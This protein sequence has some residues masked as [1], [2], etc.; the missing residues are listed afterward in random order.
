MAAS[1]AAISGN[2]CEDRNP[3]TPQAS[4]IPEPRQRLS[5]RSR[6]D[7]PTNSAGDISMT[8]GSAHIPAIVALVAGVLILIAPRFLNFIVAIYLIVVGLAGLGVFR[9]LRF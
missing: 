6:F 8:I 5:C 4:P 1:N 2:F 3:L 9:M 7:Y